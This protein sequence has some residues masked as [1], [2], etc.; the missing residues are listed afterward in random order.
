MVLERRVPMCVYIDIWTMG[1]KTVT[2]SEPLAIVH[3]GKASLPKGFS[4][5]PL[6][7]SFTSMETGF[8]NV[9]HRM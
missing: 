2:E 6:P 9:N 5:T 7:A 3:L 4:H 1:S 8:P